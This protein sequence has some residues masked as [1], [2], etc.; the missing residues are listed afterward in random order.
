MSSVA[1]DSPAEK[2]GIE[3]GDIIL[4]FNDKVIRKFSDLPLL[5]E[6]EKPADKAAIEIWRSGKV[7]QLGAT[8]G[9][10]KSDIV[11]DNSSHSNVKLG[12]AVRSLTADEK[13]GNSRLSGLMVE[14]VSGPAARAGIESGDVIVAI[15]GTQVKSV[16][17][18][19]KI[20]ATM[21]T[22]LAVL[23]QRGDAKIFI[24]VNL[25]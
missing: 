1:A 10:V 25:S 8:L 11:A 5:V 9:E 2:A 17:D 23:I 24:P 14:D 13:K 6:T 20:V 12:V 3:V 19:Q 7:I 16:E 22:R 15:N 18:L 21:N 4:K